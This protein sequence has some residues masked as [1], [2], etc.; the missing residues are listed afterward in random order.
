MSGNT[1][2]PSKATALARMQALIAGT[3]KHF[4]N[5]QFTLGNTAYTTQSLTALFQSVVDAIVAVTAAQAS[6]KDAVAAM[7]AVKAKVAPVVLD[8]KRFLIAT[9]RSAAQELTDFGLTPPKAR[10]PRTSAEN[11][12]AA[13][14]AKATRSARGTVGKKKKLTIK[15]DVKG[16]LVVPVTE[17]SANAPPPA[18]PA[19]SASSAPP[20]GAPP[21]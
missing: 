6:A 3:L 5:G 17:S 16:V 14:K 11:A 8:Y 10:T 20:T 7:R 2:K 13:A 21:K 19:P 4:P 9:F 18:Q 15:G 1:S 12:A